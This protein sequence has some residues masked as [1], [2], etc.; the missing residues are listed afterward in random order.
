MCRGRGC[1]PIQVPLSWCR[2][3]EMRR[4]RSGLPTFQNRHRRAGV[5]HDSRRAPLGAASHRCARSLLPGRARASWLR[6]H[7]TDYRA[8]HSGSASRTGSA[9]RCGPRPPRRR[10]HGVVGGEATVSDLTSDIF[11]RPR[12]LGPSAPFSV[13]ARGVRGRAASRS[14]RAH[15]TA[16]ARRDYLAV[17]AGSMTAVVSPRI[18][19]TLPSPA[20]RCGHRWARLPRAHDGERFVHTFALGFEVIPNPT[21]PRDRLVRPSWG[22]RRPCWAPPGSMPPCSGPKPRS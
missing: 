11:R 5:A 14:A 17:D 6:T 21:P 13:G 1:G 9:P 15:V 7:F 16:G 3:G 2:R 22:T 8:S 10:A 4:Q 18:G 19:G 12:P 20:G